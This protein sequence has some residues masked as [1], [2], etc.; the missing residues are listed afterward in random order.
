M[1][2]LRLK[3]NRPILNLIFPK[4]TSE[5]RG[6]TFNKS[7]DQGNNIKQGFQGLSVVGAF[8]NFC[9]ELEKYSLGSMLE[10]VLNKYRSELLESP[11][12]YT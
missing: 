11:R 7:L 10:S 4:Y 5:K 9:F 3:K 12:N 2:L 1:V 6:L 8:T